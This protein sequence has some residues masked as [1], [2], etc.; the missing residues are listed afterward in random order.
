[1]VI[2][3]EIGNF[4]WYRNRIMLISVHHYLR[5][6]YS[7]INSF[8]LCIVNV[9]CCNK[10][11]RVD[12]KSKSISSFPLK[13]IWKYA[14]SFWHF[15]QFCCNVAECRKW[16]CKSSWKSV[17]AIWFKKMQNLKCLKL[18]FVYSKCQV[19]RCLLVK[20]VRTNILFV[21]LHQ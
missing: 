21:Q 15:M 2:G 7:L 14:N 13:F 6:I 19:L 8:Q 18:W 20:G 9:S 11:S 1:M 5:L 3:S 4:A 12:E 17:C 16:L 10:L